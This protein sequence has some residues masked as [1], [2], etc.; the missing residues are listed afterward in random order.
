MKTRT[1]RS[2]AAC[3]LKSGSDVAIALDEPREVLFVQFFWI[4]TPPATDAHITRPL[5]AAAVAVSLTARQSPSTPLLAACSREPQRLF[6]DGCIDGCDGLLRAYPH[7][8]GLDNA[9]IAA[10]A[11]ILQ[12]HAQGGP[13]CGISVRPVPSR[14]AYGRICRTGG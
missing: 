2:S 6:P 9:D 8:P 5:C 12:G 7:T 13:Q 11:R 10:M 14:R 3:A 1:M 4:D